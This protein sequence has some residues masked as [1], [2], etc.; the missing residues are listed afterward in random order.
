MEDMTSRC[1]CK[2]TYSNFFQVEYSSVYS[3]PFKEHTDWL[4]VEPC[5]ACTCMSDSD[6]N[7]VTMEMQQ[8]VCKEFK[9][10]FWVVWIVNIVLSVA[11][12]AT[13]I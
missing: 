7:V 10:I 4:D 8:Q 2:W 5:S 12:F 13:K 1:Y 6:K 9:G 11:S 3:R